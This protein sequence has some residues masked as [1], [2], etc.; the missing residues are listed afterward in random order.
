MCGCA[1]REIVARLALEALPQLRVGRQVLGQHLDG[2]GALEARVARP[3]DL[4]HAARAD[5]REDF[6]G[7]E[8]MACGKRQ[9]VSCEGWVVA[10]YFEGRT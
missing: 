9:I 10:S 4:A 6:V 7:A 8:P 3:V 2:D 1:E 5:R